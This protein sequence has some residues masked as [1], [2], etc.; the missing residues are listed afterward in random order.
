MK[1]RR[2]LKKNTGLIKKLQAQQG[3]RSSGFIGL[4]TDAPFH[5]NKNQSTI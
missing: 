4:S 2:I 3:Y 5:E 1:N